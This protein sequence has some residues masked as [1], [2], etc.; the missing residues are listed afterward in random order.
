[1]SGPPTISGKAGNLDA[2]EIAR[3]ENAPTSLV[4]PRVHCDPPY[5]AAVLHGGP[6][7]P[8]SVVEVAREIARDRGVLEPFQTST[9]IDGQVTELRD[10]LE[11]HAELPV[12]LVGCSWG[13]MLGWITAARHPDLVRTLV[14]VGS[15]PLEARYAAGIWDNRLARLSP[16]ERAE[17][18]QIAEALGDLETSGKDAILARLGELSGKADAYDPLPPDPGPD[19]API[20]CRYEDFAGVWTEAAALRREGGF[21]ALAGL[22]RCPVV[23][24]H[25]D[26]D[27]HPW[28]GIAE[29]LSAVLRD[30]RMVLLP[31]CGHEPW[32]ERRARDAFFDALRD[33]LDAG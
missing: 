15:G 8:G 32:R 29:P 21:M 16:A 5:R 17:M 10:M 23:A 1:M 19:L 31:E 2:E 25:G 24:I 11:L 20:P 22:I 14:L 28:Q 12:A 18:R 7:A 3:V 6:G 9:T 27:P 13:A 33:A 26:Y 30:F 4:N